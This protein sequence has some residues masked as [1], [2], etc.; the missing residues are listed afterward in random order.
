MSALHPMC[1]RNMSNSRSLLLRHGP[2]AHH[3][4]QLLLGR[5]RSHLHRQRRLQRPARRY[6]ERPDRS[7]SM[8]PSASLDGPSSSVLPAIGRA[9]KR[10]ESVEPLSKPHRS[11]CPSASSKPS[12]HIVAPIVPVVL[13]TRLSPVGLP[14]A[15][16]HCAQPY[17]SRPQVAQTQK[18]WGKRPVS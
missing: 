2:T 4:P 14:A 8:A 6:R 11:D 7:D 5:R 15:Q 3:W 9:D 16:L 1:Q 13:S 18:R 10:P 17:C 12:L